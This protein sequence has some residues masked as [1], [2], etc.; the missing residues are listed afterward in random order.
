LPLMTPVILYD[1]ILG[2]SLGLQIFTQVFIIFGNN[3]PGSPVGSTLMYVPYLYNNAFRYS[4]MGVASAVSMIL[5]AITI[6]L[7]VLIFRS[8]KRWV[9]YDTI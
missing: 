8:A 1:I 3:P 2:V 9:N 4:E 5:F 7:S 6:V